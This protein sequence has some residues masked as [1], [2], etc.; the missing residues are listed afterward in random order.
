[1]L[2]APGPPDLERRA[3]NVKDLF[4]LA[5]C[6]NS[7]ASWKLPKLLHRVGILDEIAEFAHVVFP[8]GKRTW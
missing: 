8:A 6:E 2:L 3:R 1:M 4:R 7:K 5:G